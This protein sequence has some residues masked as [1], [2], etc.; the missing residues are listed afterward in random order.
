M[1]IFI[2]GQEVFDRPD[3]AEKKTSDT[4]HADANS[5]AS[6]LDRTGVGGKNKEG[7]RQRLSFLAKTD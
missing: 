1:L 4:R 6:M 3:L 2:I 7:Q 5:A